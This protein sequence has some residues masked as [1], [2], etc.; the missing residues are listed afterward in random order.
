VKLN[1]TLET[2]RLAGPAGAPFGLFQ[3]GPLRIISSG[4]PE[5]GSPGWPWEHVSVSTETRCPTWDEMCRVKDWFWDAEE[6]VIQFH[7]PRSE[8]VNHHRFCLHLWRNLEAPT[9]SPPSELVG[10]KPGQS[11]GKG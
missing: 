4:T 11:S 1:P 8:Y 3:V 6:T 9:A 5:P 10:P 2:F 7:P